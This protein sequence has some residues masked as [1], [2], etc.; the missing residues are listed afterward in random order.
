M[1]D[2]IH[3]IDL[4]IPPEDFLEQWAAQF[5][6]KVDLNVLAENQV[7]THH[8]AKHF[9]N[10]VD[11]VLIALQARVG[12]MVVNAAE[13]YGG[14][15]GVK[16]NGSLDNDDIG[17]LQDMINALGETRPD[18]SWGGIIQL[19]RGT[20]PYES[21]LQMVDGVSLRGQGWRATR[22]IGDL[23]GA[24]LF[25]S[26]DIID[27]DS[28]DRL[29]GV[30]I[31]DLMIDNGSKLNADFVGIDLSNTN[32]SRVSGIRMINVETGLRVIGRAYYNKYDDIY[33]R[34]AIKGV[35][36]AYSANGN[37]FDDIQIDDIDTGIEVS[38]GDNFHT[39]NQLLFN[40]C[41]IEGANNYGFRFTPTFDQGVYDIN[42]LGGRVEGFN[43]AI[44][45]HIPAFCRTVRFHTPYLSSLATNYVNSG[46][47][48]GCNVETFGHDNLQIVDKNNH[49]SA[50]GLDW[51][52]ANDRLD[53]MKSVGADTRADL[54]IQSIDARRKITC[55]EISIG[56]SN[57]IPD[58]NVTLSAN[59]GAGATFVTEAPV[60]NQMGKITITPN[61]A[62]IAAGADVTIV[63]VDSGFAAKPRMNVTRYG[64]GQQHDKAV[65]ESATQ[66]IITE[67]GLPVAGQPQEFRWIC[68]GSA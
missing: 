25:R 5:V 11:N 59:W 10:F 1:S 54:G 22:F 38:S 34:N 14:S 40:H 46:I 61:G 33:V 6:T 39:T 45:I 9:M 21:G 65:F 67:Q 16:A 20:I 30:G 51:K 24:P 4:D 12:G 35:Y 37:Y 32:R 28:N 15:G 7:V 63:F 57:N 56:Y 60:R 13:G 27:P 62:G 55:R 53:V 26:A 42:V 66:M 44:G 50:V 41:T 52:S 8:S 58:V 47:P 43:T 29:D 2:N 19:P 68:L 3:I 23:D 49:N 31:Y 17:R 18:G 48:G 36:I 64:Y